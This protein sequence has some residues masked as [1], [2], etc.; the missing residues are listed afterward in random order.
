MIVAFILF[1]VVVLYRMVLGFAGSDISWLPNFAPVAAIALCGPSLF[2]SRRM[3]LLL[4]LAI[5]FASDVALNL[6]YGVAILTGEMF[7]RYLALAM[8]VMVGFYMRG[9]RRVSGFML[10]SLGGSIGFYLLT[11]TVSWLTSVQYAKTTMGWWQAL[12]VGLPGYPPT[13]IFFRNSLVG[14]LTFTL[15]FIGCLALGR[16]W[17]RKK[18]AAAAAE[19]P[20]L[21]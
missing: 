5:L 3:A 20:A 21:G 13:W 12:T 10:A 14:D 8:I 18:D 16:H 17:A 4:P 9:S 15:L 2:R 6:H 1:S 7:I 11:N 19:L